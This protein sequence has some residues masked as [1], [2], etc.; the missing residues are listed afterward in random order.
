MKKLLSLILKFLDPA[1][2]CTLNIIIKLEKPIT[3]FQSNNILIAFLKLSPG[4]WMGWINKP[5]MRPGELRHMEWVEL[6]LEQS[7]WL[8]P[9]SKTKPRRDHYVPLATQVVLQLRELR[10]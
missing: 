6:D 3:M 5:M 4:V 10:P 7:E 1:L 2:V 9:G 8:I